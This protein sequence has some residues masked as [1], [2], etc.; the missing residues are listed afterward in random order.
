RI[1]V[2][3]WQPVAI[4]TPVDR[5][6]VYLSPQGTI[7]G[8]ATARGVLPL[9]DGPDTGSAPG[10]LA[11]D[12]RLLRPLVNIE[13]GLPGMIGQRVNHFQFDQC[14]NLTLYGGSGWRA[15][16][17]RML[18]PSDYGTL[19][20]KVAALRSVAP[21]VDFKNPGVYV[22]LENPSEVTVGHGPDVAPTP[23]PTPTPPPTPTP[24]PT[25]TPTPGPVSVITPTP[26]ATPSTSPSPTPAAQGACS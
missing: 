25:A 26:K 20:S 4:Y 7:L 6:A 23:T 8:P 2:D 17:G 18:T 5:A 22:N 24:K 13:Q 11:I 15:M 14:W 10:H 9:I 21:D 16:F 1:T 19:Q 3:E 12:Q